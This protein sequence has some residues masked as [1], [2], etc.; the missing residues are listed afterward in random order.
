MEQSLY[1]QLGGFPAVRKII[2]SFYNKVL[3]DETL[4]PLF[5]K[6]EMSTVMDHQTKFFAMLLGGPA[7][8]SDKE[9]SQIHDRLKVSSNHFKLT[10]EYLVETLEDFNLSIEQIEYLSSEFNK[11]QKLVVRE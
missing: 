2:V 1:D 5:E 10:G 9:I 8:Y 4:A 7:S 11:R 3:D 6:S